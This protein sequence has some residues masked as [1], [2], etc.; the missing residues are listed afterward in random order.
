MRLV[1]KQHVND[2]NIDFPAPDL[3]PV[4]IFLVYK[5]MSVICFACAFY[6]FMQNAPSHNNYSE[7]AR[8]VNNFL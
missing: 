5:R 6:E 3:E 1:K 8:N 7:F 2:L 4:L